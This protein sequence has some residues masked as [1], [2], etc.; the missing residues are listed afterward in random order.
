[1]LPVVAKFVSGRQVTD[2]SDSGLRDDAELITGAAAAWRMP[3]SSTS[4]PG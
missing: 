3:V 4:C 1:V 2:T